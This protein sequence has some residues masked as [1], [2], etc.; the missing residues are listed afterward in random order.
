M[1]TNTPL[2]VVVAGGGIGGLALANGLR[3]AGVA[4]SVHEREVRRTDRLQG[5]RIHIN[6]HGA[7]ALSELLSPAL[8]G[9]FVAAAGKGGNGFGFVTEQFDRL[10]DFAVTDTA[11]AADDHY[12]ISRITLRQLLLADLGDTVRYGSMFEHYEH[13]PDGRVVA[14]F[15]DGTTEVGDVLV[16]ADGGTSRVRAQYLPHAERVDTGI[17]TIS[18]KYPLTEA[19]RARLDPRLLRHP[20]SVIPPR[21]CGMFLAPHEFTPSAVPA[22]DGLPPGLLFDDSQPYVFWAFA[23]ERAR[24]GTDLTGLAPAALHTI[25][26]RMTGGWAPELRRLVAESDPATTTLIP[27]KTSVPVPRWTPTTVTLLGDAIHSMTPFAGIGANTALRDAQLLCRMLVAADRRDRGL[28][29]A[30]GAYEAAMTDYGF[31][32]VRTSLDTAERAVA[33][34]RLGR[35]MGKL[36]L[37]AA[38]AVPAMKRKM[39]ADLGA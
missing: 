27:I 2:K 36:V 16:G 19:T 15:A 20:W 37:R 12:G 28:L 13:R 17:V 8:F 7:A 4:V 33:D 5:F 23:A 30:I 32:A 22:A 6:P 34:G 38:G 21:G 1:A 14:Y 31:A 18:G 24:F 29:D 10:V 9:A 35:L 25:A 3:R 11:D 26:N 39:F